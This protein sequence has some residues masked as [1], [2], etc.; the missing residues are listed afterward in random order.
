M[1]SKPDPE[2]TT[3]PEPTDEGQ[4]PPSVEEKPGGCGCHQAP[5]SGGAFLWV[6]S[7]VVVGAFVARRRFAQAA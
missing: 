3:A 5:S 2:P 6:A 1:T 7:L 4:V